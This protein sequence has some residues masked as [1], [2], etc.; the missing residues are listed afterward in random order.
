MKIFDIL[1]PIMIGPSS[2]HTAGAC[3]IAKM[4]SVIAGAGFNEVIFE[5]HGS[6]AE[7]YQGHGTDK[8]L[9]AGVMGCN[10]DD[11]RIRNSY[12]IADKNGLKYSFEKINLGEVH[13]NSVKINFIYNDNFKFYVIG[14]SIGGGNII[15][16]NI[17][18]TDV[19]FT[20]DYPTFI[21]KYTDQKGIISFI[22][23]LLS[24]AGY[25]IESMKTIKNGKEVSLI[26]ETDVEVDT[27]IK[28]KILSDNRFKFA[29][30]IISNKHI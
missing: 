29:K 12:N 18:G 5:L 21:I 23:T 17:N 7:T 11:E 22:S 26:V 27:D 14:S 10:P 2:S 6:F 16:I 15:I 3:R 8:A 1:G 28:N 9:L 19:N 30:Y 4:A 20:G 25:N 13:P 24:E